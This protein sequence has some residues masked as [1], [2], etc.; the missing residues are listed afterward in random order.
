M[1]RASLAA[2]LVGAVTLG[3]TYWELLYL[4]IGA[5]ILLGR[6]AQEPGSS[7]ALDERPH[8]SG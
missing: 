6:L 5:A 1:L 7:R 4:L 8:A 3:I 2:Y